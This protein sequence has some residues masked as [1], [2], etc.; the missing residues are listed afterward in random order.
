MSSLRVGVASALV[1][2]AMLPATIVI[3]VVRRFVEAGWPGA[4]WVMHAFIAINLL[5]A[6]VGGPFLAVRAERL[7]RRRLIAALSAALDGGLLLLV[8]LA[9]PLAVLLLLRFVQGAFY[10]AGVSILMGSIRR[11]AKTGA[12][13]GL[14]GGAVV[15][16]ILVGIPLGAVLG[17][18]A[19]TLPLV[20]GGAV[21]VLTGVLTPLLL[22]AATDAQRSEVT[23]RELL[24]APLLRGP[25]VVVA[26]ERF[27]VGAFVVTL[28]LYGHVLGVSDDRVSAW[29]SVFL[30]VFA[31]ATWP[32]ARL[33]DRVDRW[34]LVAVGASVYGLTFFALPLAPL[35]ALPYVFAAGG[36]ASA[37]I[38]GPSLGLAAAAVPASS[39]ASAMAVLNAAGTLGMF[40]GSTLAGA[41][42]GLLIHGGVAR[43]TAYAVVFAAAGVAQL[44]SVV[45]AFFPARG[46]ASLPVDAR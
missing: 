46:P 16:S 20:V 31:L 43:A 29:F 32:F 2:G 28:Q 33:G 1:F 42:S 14:V 18:V 10:I 22:P 4:E 30:T 41:L 6:C 3:P 40:V 35:Q 7:S 13:M 19:P 36:L 44:G 23:F 25:T 38:Y 21:G 8:T 15:L 37:S 39:R 9:P 27:A 17:K 24:R 26:L 11:Q 34:K 45:L 5:G 12:A